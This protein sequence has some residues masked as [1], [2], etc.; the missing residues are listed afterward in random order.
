MNAWNAPE[1]V[2]A[3]LGLGV[4]ATLLGLAAALLV[5]LAVDMR[6]GRP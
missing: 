2:A 1:V 5:W 3:L 4:I 6:D